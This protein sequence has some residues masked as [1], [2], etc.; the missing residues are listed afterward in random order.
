MFRQSIILFVLLSLGVFVADS[1]VFLYQKEQET[2]A[3]LFFRVVLAEDDDEEELLL[4][5]SPVWVQATQ[6]NT[7]EQHNKRNGRDMG[8]LQR[9]TD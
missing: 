9:T 8:D 5:S 6:P 4:D 1:R 7:T 3:P 2:L